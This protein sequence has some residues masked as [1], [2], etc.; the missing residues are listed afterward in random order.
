MLIESLHA[1]GEVDETSLKDFTAA[2]QAAPAGCLAT[3]PFTGSN[4]SITNAVCSQYSIPDLIWTAHQMQR[5]QHVLPFLEQLLLTATAVSPDDCPV[6]HETLSLLAEASTKP[7]MQHSQQAI[8][9]LLLFW[10]LR[11]LPLPGA[12]R[13]W[14][15][16]ASGLS[17]TADIP[18][19]FRELGAF[20]TGPVGMLEKTRPNRCSKAFAAVQLNSSSAPPS[21]LQEAA[22][23]AA[24][25]KDAPFDIKVCPIPDCVCCEIVQ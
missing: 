23:P 10:G 13:H 17:V 18:N 8:A 19:Q 1:E 3:W 20:S 22:T 12:L 6:L 14:R 16:E 2:L 4:N 5:V 24:M 7:Q 11:E 25:Q 9:K 15:D 21:S